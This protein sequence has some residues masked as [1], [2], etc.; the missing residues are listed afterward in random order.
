MAFD[1]DDIDQWVTTDTRD[2]LMSRIGQNLCVGRGFSVA[3]LNVDHLVKLE[4]DPEFR[5]AYAAQDFV[6]ADGNPIVW[7]RRIAGHRTALVPG[8][9][10]VEPVA[11]M[12]AQLGVPVALIGAT[13]YALDAAAGKLSEDHKDLVV[14]FT[15]APQLGFD[16]LGPE[17]DALI[18][19]L[20]D[21]SAGLVF[22]A[23]GAP[24]QEVFAARIRAAVPHIGIL[25][26]GAGLDFLAGSQR[27]APVFVRRI[28]MEW[29]WRILMNPRRL[30]VRY[31]RCAGVLPRHIRR[32]Y[33]AR[34]EAKSRLG[35][36][37]AYPKNEGFSARRDNTQL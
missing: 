1:F 12:A 36:V 33:R 35:F 23:L 22:L 16:P 14:S 3:T 10:L 30:L 21:S 8:S 7:M 5:A 37:S 24:K 13:D 2:G 17:A 29:A 27:R 19:R 20:R 4:K 28:A 9:E 31:I 15:A 26:I 11:E 34:Q 6:V 18:E 32:A 25:S